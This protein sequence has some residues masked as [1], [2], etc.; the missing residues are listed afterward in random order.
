MMNKFY[1]LVICLFI[2]LT[3]NSQ[4]TIDGTLMHD[5]ELREYTLYVP[6]SY[7]GTAEV[8]LVFNFHGYTSNAGQQMFYGNFLSLA[9]THGFI[10]VHPQGL[11]DANGIT[12][13]N[14]E[15]QSDVDDIGFSSA[16]ID[17]IASEYSIDLD[18]VYSTGMSNG[19]FMSYTLACRLSERFAAIASVTGTMTI[20]QL[21]DCAAERAVPVM[22]I[23]GTADPTVPY[24]GS[25]WMAPVDDV[26]AYWV[27]HNNCNPNPVVTDMPN[28]DP[29]DGSTVTRS[30]YSQ[31]D[32]NSSV[33]LLKV[34]GGAH[35]WPGTVFSFAG[36]NQD[37]N[38]SEL[39][40]EFFSQYDL[41]G[42]ISNTEDLEHS[43]IEVYPNPTTNQLTIDGLNINDQ[44]QIHTL[45]GQKMSNYRSV[46]N[47]MTIDLNHLPKG[48]YLLC[49]TGKNQSW[50]EV[51]FKLD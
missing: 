51:I 34:V 21:S 17:H 2:G 22:E 8:P 31:G 10:V 37:I 35:T 6:E 5:D 50:T 14:A 19:G 11:L 27:E 9:D 47:S 36:T 44:I 32:E 25:D 39:I 45:T 4:E 40:W 3:V 48:G 15:W 28:T 18:R 46:H 41:N 33:E 30:V 20:P 23:H 26:I 49:V 29:N 16:L 7:D 43:S 12:H 1:F 13:F 42:A 24:D 38:A